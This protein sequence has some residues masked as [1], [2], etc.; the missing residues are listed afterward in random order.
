MSIM[1]VST[2]LGPRFHA[3]KIWETFIIGRDL[4]RYS[5]NVI[6]LYSQKIWLRIM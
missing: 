1:A 4:I 2:L 5:S 3:C 6:T